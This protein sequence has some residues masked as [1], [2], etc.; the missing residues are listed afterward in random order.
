MVH[1]DPRGAGLA[2]PEDEAGRGPCCPHLGDTV[3]RAG[4]ELGAWT[5]TKTCGSSCNTNGRVLYFLIMS[6]QISEFR[7]GKGCRMPPST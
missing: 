2:P 3:P 5:E 4:P 7:K 6:S 1:E